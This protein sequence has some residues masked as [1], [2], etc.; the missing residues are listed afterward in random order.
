MNKTN[1]IASTRVKNLNNRKNTELK[2]IRNSNK[3]RGRRE[4]KRKMIELY[5][6]WKK[7]ISR[8]SNGRR[9]QKIEIE[10]LSKI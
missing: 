7:P 10:L 8:W 1:Q 6:K 3:H 4:D 9:N 5:L 2:W